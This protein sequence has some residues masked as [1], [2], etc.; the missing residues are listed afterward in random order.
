MFENMTFEY[1]LQSMM[2][3]VPNAFD[4]REGSIMYNALAPIN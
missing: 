1:L 3:R 2:D 4:K